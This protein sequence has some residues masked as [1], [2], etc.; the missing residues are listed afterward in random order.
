MLHE[1]RNAS[2]S[3]LSAFPVVRLKIFGERNTGTNYLEELIAAN[4]DCDICPGNLSN[5]RRFTYNVL[6]W[7]LPYKFARYIVEAN[8]DRQYEKLFASELG[9][10][11]AKIPNLPRGIKSYPACTGFI[12]LVK[13]PYAWLLSLHARP[14]QNEASSVLNFSEFLR[15]PWFTVEREHAGVPSYPNP[16]KVWNDKVRS[17]RRLSAFG[18]SMIIRYEDVL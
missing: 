9:W 7:T 16:I 14:Y 12:A 8:R 2:L 1:R 10:K 15:A 6:H 5:A 13:N 18:P 17:Y 11:H 4:F 3:S